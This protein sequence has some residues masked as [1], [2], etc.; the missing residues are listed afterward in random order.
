[1]VGAFGID[2]KHWRARLL[3]DEKN[4]GSYGYNGE[5]PIESRAWPPTPAAPGL[6]VPNERL[7]GITGAEKPKR[8]PL[9]SSVAIKGGKAEVIALTCFRVAQHLIG[10]VD[11]GGQRHPSLVAPGQPIRVEHPH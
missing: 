4:Q 1:L 3:Q 2:P 6:R 9:K 8:I 7:H 5:Q 11:S 10:R